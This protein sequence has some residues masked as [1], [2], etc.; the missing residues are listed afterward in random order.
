M[1]TILSGPQPIEHVW[2]KIKEGLQ[3]RFPEIATMPG[4][5][6]AILQRLAEVLPIIWEEEI[7]GDYLETLWRSMPRRVA[8]IIA[9]SCIS[10]IVLTFQRVRTV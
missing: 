10:G 8:A 9:G 5:P 1:A 7:T 6:G 4:G 3:I 2:R